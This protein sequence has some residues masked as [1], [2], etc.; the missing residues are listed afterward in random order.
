ME[1]TILIKF[2]GQRQTDYGGAGDDTGNGATFN[3]FEKALVEFRVRIAN[4]YT[5]N[6]L[7]FKPKL[8]RGSEIT[9]WSKYGEGTVEIITKNGS[10]TSSNIIYKG[11]PLCAL[12]NSD[13]EYIARDKI[14]ANKVY[15][16]CMSEIFDGSDDEG[17][18]KVSAS[19]NAYTI[20][21][22][23]SAKRTNTTAP[24]TCTH[25]KAIA[26]DDRYQDNT[27]FLNNTHISI[28]YNAKTTLEE[29]KAWLKA[30][31]ITI[32][33]ELLTPIVEDINGSN[34]TVQYDESTTIYNRDNAELEVT[35]TN[36]KAVSDVYGD[37]KNIEEKLKQDIS[38]GQEIPTNDCINNKRI[39]KKIIDFGTL[40]NATLKNV[41]HNIPN[42]NNIIN[43]FGIATNISDINKNTIPIPYVDPENILNSI[44][45]SSTKDQVRIKTGTNR[46]GWNANVTIL[47][48]KED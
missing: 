2:I 24:Y 48:T 39:Y 11:K 18:L 36:N 22:K 29:F 30:N 44:S 20:P 27:F 45:L 21:L 38:K 7:V 42:I 14:E 31:P 4:G 8:I 9:T 23:Y 16:N 12:K 25:F 10:N 28:A 15:R 41:N 32:V 5:A 19:L 13:G 35:L 33:Y 6:N 43:I 1:E 17:W 26:H 37:L 3:L 47:Y 34:K 40:P 46:S